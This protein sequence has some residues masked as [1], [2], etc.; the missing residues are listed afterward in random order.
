VGATRGDVNDWV[1]DNCKSINRASAA[2]CYSCGGAREVVAMSETRA[3]N[4]TPMSAEATAPFGSLSLQG[5]VS[6]GSI[7]DAAAM[8]AA[9][10][11]TPSGPATSANLIGG[12]VAGIVAAAVA[13]ALWYGVVV[14]TN[15]QIGL[16][17]IA[18]GFIVGQGVV[19]G[20]TRRGHVALVA[21]SVVLTLLALAISEYLVAMHFLVPAL[22]AEGLV[23]DVMQPPDLMVE[24][25]IESIKAEPMTLL[26]WGIALFQAFAIPARLVG[27]R[28]GA[29]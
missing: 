24:I 19:L 8:G 11:P 26:F 14:V 20:A 13:S 17:A 27:G 4:T 3:L 9:V 12:L 21:F 16:I 15:Y 18:V 1:C 28:N 6:D 10:E 5:A 7:G 2:S 29:A 25:I 23:I 22:A